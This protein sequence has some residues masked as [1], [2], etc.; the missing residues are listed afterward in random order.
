VA[1]TAETEGKA[2]V[3]HVVQGAVGATREEWLDYTTLLG[4]CVAV[5]LHDPVAR[6]GGMAHFVF[7]RK[8]GLLTG[9]PQTGG[10]ETGSPET[11]GDARFGD[12]AIAALLQRLAGLG[13]QAPGLQA[14][15]CGGARVHEGRQD[16]GR[17]NV[18][19]ALSRLAELG[20]RVLG[21]AGL[22]EDMGGNQV[23]RIRFS[24]CSGKLVVTAQH[25]STPQDTLAGF[26]G[27]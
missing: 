3:L 11:S 13:A 24:P 15:L 14:Q 16:I 8:G 12:V 9:G 17:A 18:E 20:V 25:H 7:P 6:L 27:R 21:T 26:P 22:G 23:R 5:C 4:A 1:R 2:R 10:P 19:F